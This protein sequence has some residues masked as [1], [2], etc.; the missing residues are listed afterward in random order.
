MSERTW[1]TIPCP[2]GD[3]AGD[4]HPGVYDFDHA[5]L[6]CD[7]CGFSGSSRAAAAI[8]AICDHAVVLEELFREVEAVDPGRYREAVHR[9]EARCR[10]S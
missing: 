9:R 3:A 7:R 6:A 4:P 10:A 2:I 5:V 8:F 1:F